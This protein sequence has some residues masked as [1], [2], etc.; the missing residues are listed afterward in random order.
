[1]MR[2]LRCLHTFRM[3]FVECD[4]E[5]KKNEFSS[6]WTVTKRKHDEIQIS[7]L[8]CTFFFSCCFFFSQLDY[9]QKSLIKFYF[10]YFRFRFWT[11]E[12]GSVC[13]SAI[14]V[15]RSDIALMHTRWVLV[16]KATSNIFLHMA[17]F[18]LAR[19]QSEKEN[20]W[21]IAQIVLS[22]NRRS[23]NNTQNVDIAQIKYIWY[24]CEI[25][26]TR[27]G[28]VHRN[29]LKN[30]DKPLCWR[31]PLLCALIGEVSLISCVL[32]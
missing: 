5:W 20:C 28:R 4:W 23:P 22:R 14:V 32:A 9:T 8:C 2:C 12:N 26:R 11:I 30:S 16:S 18:M 21:Y 19:Y 15:S 13:F 7:L 24:L 6:A 27:R 1:M 31:L 10:R 25:Y 3:S 17:F 29:S